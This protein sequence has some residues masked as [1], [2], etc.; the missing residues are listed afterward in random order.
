MDLDAELLLSF[1]SPFVAPAESDRFTFSRPWMREQ[2]GRV[3]DIRR[4]DFSL[5]L[6]MTL[7]PQYLLIHRVWLGAIG[8]LS[9]LNATVPVRG[10]LV[11]WVPGFDPR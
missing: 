8:V 1:L 5:G 9:Q 3:N 11:A 10:E 6:K 2:F 4:P 7:P